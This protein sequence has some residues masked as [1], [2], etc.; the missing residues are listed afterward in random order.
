M[1]E[2]VCPV[3]IG[4]FLASPVRKLIQNPKKILGPHIKDGMKVIDIGC[5]MGFFSLPMARMV[6]SGGRVVCVDMQEKMIKSLE[7]RAL[8]AGLLDRIETRVCHQNT[9]GI[10]DIKEQIDMAIAFA[11]V[12]E[13]PDI[14]NLFSEIYE[15]VKQGGRLLVA[16]PKG[17]ASQE[18]FKKTISIARGAGFQ[19]IDEPEVGQSRAILFQ[20]G[21]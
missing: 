3:W 21:L 18:D 2:R 6:G 12:H 20:K 8:K 17:H 1:A 19:L 5:A 9:L 16:E 11:V 14:P 13:V 15:I 10:D 4:Y 7:K